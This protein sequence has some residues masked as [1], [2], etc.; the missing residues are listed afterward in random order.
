MSEAAFRPE[1]ERVEPSALGRLTRRGASIALAWIALSFAAGCNYSSPF[2][3]QEWEDENRFGATFDDRLKVVRGLASTADRVSAAEREEI[4]QD[5]A[6]RIMLESNPLMRMELVRT[7]SAYRTDAAYGALLQAANDQSDRVR[8]VACQ[9]LGE[10]RRADAVEVL[11]A[12]LQNDASNEVRMAA[13]QALGTLGHESAAR[14]LATVLDDANPA[15]QRSAMRSLAQVT[16]RDLGENV[17]A[18]KGFTRDYLGEG[19]QSIASQQLPAEIV[20]AGGTY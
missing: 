5:L 13:A 18:W 19:E 17:A 2:R 1:S 4:S 3:Y 16:G 14:P 12:A 11:A 6:R 7:I 8:R 10:F 9:G 20:P 15:M